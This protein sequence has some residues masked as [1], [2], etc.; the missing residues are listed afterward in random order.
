MNIFSSHLLS[1]PSGHP[2]KAPTAGSEDSVE[3]SLASLPA[4]VYPPWQKKK[5]SSEQVSA[6]DKRAARHASCN[7]RG[8]LINYID[9]KVLP[10]FGA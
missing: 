5:T 9:L 3:E 10:F 7:L 1:T 8:E 2:E 4:L 6:E